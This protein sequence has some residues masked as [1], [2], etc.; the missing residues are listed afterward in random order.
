MRILLLFLDWNFCL[1]LLGPILSF[2]KG[3]N[4]QE[5]SKLVERGLTILKFDERLLGCHLPTVDDVVSFPA[6]ESLFVGVIRPVLVVL[7]EW[8]AS[9]SVA[10]FKLSRQRGISHMRNFL[11]FVSLIFNFKHRI[12]RKIEYSL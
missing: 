1:L 8:R 5:I 7:V 10:G 6:V 9:Q 12:K 2:A 4:F 3:V 11:C